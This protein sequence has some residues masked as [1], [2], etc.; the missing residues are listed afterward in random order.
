MH[1]KNNLESLIPII[2]L[3]KPIV[4]IVRTM[5]IHSKYKGRYCSKF[6]ILQKSDNYLYT[7]YLAPMRV[8]D[9]NM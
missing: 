4:P 3:N 5:N 6:I 2:L 7:K 8:K 1:V 9:N